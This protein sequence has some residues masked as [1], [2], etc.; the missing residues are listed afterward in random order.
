MSGL[1]NAKSFLGGD[2]TFYKDSVCNDYWRGHLLRKSVLFS[3]NFSKSVTNFL[4]FFVKQIKIGDREM[5]EKS[6]IEFLFR[7]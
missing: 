5:I 6:A 4:L 2:K 7:R 3:K 1:K